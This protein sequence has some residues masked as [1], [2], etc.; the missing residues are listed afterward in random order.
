MIQVQPLY[1]HIAC[2]L[3]IRCFFHFLA[4]SLTHMSTIAR[5]SD[6]IYFC[7]TDIN[8]T[9]LPVVVATSS[10][11]SGYVSSGSGGSS[12]D[13]PVTSCEGIYHTTVLLV[14]LFFLIPG[15]FI[16]VILS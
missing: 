5:I 10:S 1:H 6:N 12:G 8:L 4:P 2:Q 15:N 13:L 7:P 14:F 11:A 16:G 9:Y 3:L